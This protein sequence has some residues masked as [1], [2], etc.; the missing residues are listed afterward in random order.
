MGFV[1]M[2]ESKDLIASEN[3]FK[4]SIKSYVYKDVNINAR[5]KNVIT[6]V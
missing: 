2:K 6:I 4:D 5:N 3:T 1:K